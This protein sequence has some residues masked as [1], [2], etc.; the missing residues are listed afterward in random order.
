MKIIPHAGD[1]VASL[2]AA[3]RTTSPALWVLIRHWPD[4]K[5]FYADKV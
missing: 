4:L 2:Q 5:S 1:E 3:R